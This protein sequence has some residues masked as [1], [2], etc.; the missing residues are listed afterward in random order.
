MVQR[1]VGFQLA[2]KQQGHCYDNAKELLGTSASAVE[3]KR[4]YV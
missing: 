2:R 3:M 4:P 1:S